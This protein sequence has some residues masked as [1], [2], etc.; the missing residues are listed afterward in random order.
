[1]LTHEAEQKQLKVNVRK[2][3]KVIEQT[4]EKVVKAKYELQK[5]KEY[6]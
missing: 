1:M 2:E 3:K 5:K 6:L 4:K